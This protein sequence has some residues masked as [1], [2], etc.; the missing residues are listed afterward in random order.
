[1]IT[2][3][4]LSKVATYPD[5][6]L[7]DLDSLS[8]VNIFY[9]SNGSGKTTISR[10]IDS[11][12]HE[13]F[14]DCSLTWSNNDQLET[15]VYNKN[16]IEKYFK[17]DLRGI[18]TLGKDEKNNLEVINT[19]TDRITKIKNDQKSILLQLDGSDDGQGKLKD[20]NDLENRYEDIFW[21]KYKDYKPYFSNVFSMSGVGASKE[22]FKNKIIEESN[23]N[24]A[25]TLEFE[26][27]NKKIESLFSEGNKKEEK[28]LNKIDIN[29]YLELEN[30]TILK[31]KIIG[32][33][34]V[35]IAKMIE[36]LGN[37]DWVEQ[38]RQ[39]F[40]KNDNSCPFC[41]QT[42]N[43]AFAQD[44]ASY[45]DDEFKE[46]TQEL[47]D[48]DEKYRSLTNT[49]INYIE[50]IEN[51]N[52]QFINL[53][54]LKRQKELIEKKLT[55]NYSKLNNK[56]KE[57][58]IVIELET[59]SENLN[60]IN[61]I[62]EASNKEAVQHNDIIKNIE[63]NKEI[64]EMQVW[65]YVCKE[66]KSDYDSYKEQKSILSQ[67]IDSLKLKNKNIN[68]EI[69]QLNLEIETI[70][71]KISGID[72]TA[73]AINT[74]LKNL[75]F[76]SFEL[77]KSEKKGY[78]EIVRENGNDARESLSEG[79]RTLI[80]FLYFYHLVDGGVSAAKINQD[81][82]LVID[83]P[84]SSLDSDVLYVISCLIRK[85]L[86]RSKSESYHVKQ[87][88][89]LTHNVYFHREV[90][91]KLDK[92]NNKS[93]RI[94]NPQELSYW[95]VRKKEGK[96]ICLKCSTNPIKSS[97][98]LL[99]EEIRNHASSLNQLKT[100]T[101]QN[102]MRRILE[103]YFKILG[104]E[105]NLDDLIDKFEGQ[106]KT[107]C[108]SLITWMHEGSHSINDDL[109]V[110]YSDEQKDMYMIVFKKI[111]YNSNHISHYNM[112]MKISIDEANDNS[113]MKQAV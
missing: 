80:T 75:G 70:Q 77:K 47:K 86:K 88:F 50:E 21:K 59:L 17:E 60:N 108:K 71:G 18:F 74:T 8:K 33:N 94:C 1:M 61:R 6:T 113:E 23:N 85:L 38:G 31:T 92:G 28:V 54:E 56:I 20:L 48:Y 22:K 103:Y 34:D 100:V 97:Y 5:D 106:E 41:Q 110:S 101:L 104:E 89:I 112:M 109:Y 36:R 81:K 42:T 107:I 24:T 57:K 35:N 44:L 4:S 13:D 79:E 11:Q 87:I 93:N 16:F 7:C 83:D 72:A 37:S 76:I 43:Q 55:I 45:F 19:K 27:L 65:K 91:F 95:I 32:K 98:D 105:D 30:K 49:L 99:W 62:I 52:I 68:T 53:I 73:K 102:T 26:E 25:D 90:S 39:Y 63:S 84:V 46:R 82:V 14:K 15:L 9:G 67:T 66:L 29:D 64:V 69:E 58:S 40:Y 3:I 51:L 96:S 111:F 10:L 2:K 78:Y 12:E